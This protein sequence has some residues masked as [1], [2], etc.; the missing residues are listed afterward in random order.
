M[1]NIP[2]F[3]EDFLK[4]VNNDVTYKKIYDLGRECQQKLDEIDKSATLQHAHAK[5][6]EHFTGEPAKLKMNERRNF[7]EGEYKYKII[8]EAREHVDDKE[9]FKELAE[10]HKPDPKYEYDRNDKNIS[11][12][13]DKMN[14]MLHNFREKQE[15]KEQQAATQTEREKRIEDLKKQWEQNKTRLFDR[16][17]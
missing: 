9:K 10:K 2:N 3:V 12:S 16:D 4:E 6:A 14:D 8:E 1:S 5:M 11:A 7:V 13:Q 17:H 15:A